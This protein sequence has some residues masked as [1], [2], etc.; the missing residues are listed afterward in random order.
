MKTGLLK[1]SL[2]FTLALCV[3]GALHAGG[4]HPGSMGAAQPNPGFGGQGPGVPGGYPAEGRPPAPPAPKSGDVPRGVSTTRPA[5]LPAG[6][7]WDDRNLAMSIGLSKDQQRKMDTIFNNNKPAILDDYSKLQMAESK[8]QALMKQPQPD[9]ERLFVQIDAVGRARAALEKVYMQMQ[10]Q[11][12]E[13][14]QP[15]QIARLEKLREKPPED[16]VN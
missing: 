14:M 9:K 4:A 5:P 11:I 8:V 16:T 13:Q 2:C 10:L 7:W 1:G 12:R 3:A 6:R 15:E